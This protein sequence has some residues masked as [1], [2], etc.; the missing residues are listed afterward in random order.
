MKSHL[1]LAILSLLGTVATPAFSAG[2]DCTRAAAGVETAICASENLRKLD[3]QLSLVY[4][5]LAAAQGPARATLRRAQVDWLR[6][7]DRCGTDAN[8]IAGRYE[9]RLA[10]LRLQLRDVNAYRPDDVDRAALEE[11][12]QAVETARKTDAEFP[13]E[14][15]IDALSIKTGIT[16]FANAYDGNPAGS[17]AQFPTTRPQGV[18]ADEWRALRASGIEGGGENGAGAYT[19]LDVDGDGQR[20]LVIDTYVGGTG[21]FGETTVLRRKGGRF[22]GLAA[23]AQSSL[24]DDSGS[25]LYATGGRGANQSGQWI[26]L[27][28]RV[29]AAYRNSLYGVDDVYLLRPLTIVGEVPRLTVRYRYRLSIPKVQGDEKGIKTTLD[30]VLH[31]AL[32]QALGKIDTRQAR[33]IGPAD[34]PLCPVP[35]GTSDDERSNYTSYG[36]GHYTFEIVGDV[37]VWVGR[38]C[39]IGRV[40]DWFGAYSSK[41]GLGAAFWVRKPAE[42]DREQTYAVEGVRSATGTTA[43]IARFDV[44]N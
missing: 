30:G 36:T 11:L 19:L 41:G 17:V 24:D 16:S 27:R 18:T 14:K 32:S 10:A 35:E 29:Y 26:R 7:R 5:K 34:V 8:C 43:S 4:G 44:G 31:A 12:R 23:P 2:L 9:E 38:D 20:D 40:V 6:V 39:R 3:F 28:G 13:L 1:S 33:D 15:V 42:P 21:L 22:E 37:P 25:I